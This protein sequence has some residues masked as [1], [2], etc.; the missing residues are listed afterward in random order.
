M[1]SVPLRHVSH[2]S[3]GV[4]GQVRWDDPAVEY[5]AGIV[6]G[7]DD[8]AAWDFVNTCRHKMKRMYKHNMTIIR[9]VKKARYRKDSYS[10]LIENGLFVTPK[11]EGDYN[12]QAPLSDAEDDGATDDGGT[13]GGEENNESGMNGVKSGTDG[14]E[15]D[16]ET[17]DESDVDNVEGTRGVEDAEDDG[18][19]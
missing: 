3:N 2:L 11:F 7:N 9:D 14:L 18:E 16:V 10:R 12:G 6:L 1:A 5:E 15:S 8:T 19:E 17:S 13:S 4:I